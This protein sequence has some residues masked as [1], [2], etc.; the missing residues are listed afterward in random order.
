MPSNKAAVRKL[1]DLY[2][3]WTT[4]LSLLRAPLIRERRDV[5]TS[6]DRSKH[7]S[8]RRSLH[9]GEVV[10]IPDIMISPHLTH[11]ER[12]QVILNEL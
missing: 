10:L 12:Q 3:G 6:P 2:D 4:I 9:S 5:Q 7:C 8:S 11:P 1:H